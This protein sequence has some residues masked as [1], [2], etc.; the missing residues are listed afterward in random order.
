[1]IFSAYKL[2]FIL[3]DHNPTAGAIFQSD[4]GWYGHVGYVESVNA[5]GF[6]DWSGQ[7][8]VNILNPKETAN[9]STDGRTTLT[10]PNRGYS[11]WV[12]QRDVP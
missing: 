1:M 7:T 10:T 4:S 8:L 5:D 12:L 9:V 11:I 3:V 2:L 6:T